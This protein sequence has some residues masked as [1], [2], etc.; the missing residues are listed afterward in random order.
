MFTSSKQCVELFETNTLKTLQ[1]SNKNERDLLTFL[2]LKNPNYVDSIC[3]QS[4][5]NLL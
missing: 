3:W 2:L 1:W 4:M 5:I